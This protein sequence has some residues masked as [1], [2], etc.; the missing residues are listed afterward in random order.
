MK[1][2]VYKESN[3]TFSTIHS[4]KGLE[5]DTVFVIDLVEGMLPSNKALEDSKKILLEEE[6]RLFYVAMTRAKS[7]LYL[8]YPKK[9]NSN[10][11]ELSRF[12]AELTQY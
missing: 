5:Y 12:V 11:S 1:K 10:N 8:I 4:V 2:P 9:H 6:R 3:L 7:D